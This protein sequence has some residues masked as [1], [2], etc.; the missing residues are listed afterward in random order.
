MP[1]QILSGQES[2]M[3]FKAICL[4]AHLLQEAN[5]YTLPPGWK[6]TRGLPGQFPSSELSKNT[7]MVMETL[8]KQ[9][10]QTKWLVERVCIRFIIFKNKSIHSSQ[11]TIINGFTNKE[12]DT[13]ALHFLLQVAT[14]IPFEP[15]A[16]LRAWVVSQEGNIAIEAMVFLLPINNLS[17]Q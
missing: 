15:N 3:S 7:G 4:S 13:I 17:S 10:V 2:L 11:M 8:G 9:C 14:Y 5:A 16:A 12:T 6:Q 1:F